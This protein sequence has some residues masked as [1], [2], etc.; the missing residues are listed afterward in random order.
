MFS[1]TPGEYKALQILG[2]CFFWV[3]W[4]GRWAEILFWQV[5]CST[6]TTGPWSTFGVRKLKKTKTYPWHYVHSDLMAEVYYSVYRRMHGLR[7]TCPLQIPGDCKEELWVSLSPWCLFIYSGLQSRH[8]DLQSSPHDS[9]KQPKLQ[10]TD[11]DLPLGFSIF[12]IPW[13]LEWG[14]FWPFT[15]VLVLIK[16]QNKCSDL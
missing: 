15:C 6:V 7:L 16:E 8:W 1:Q 2:R 9:N 4:I 13:G 5:P 11:S 3:S 12:K 10:R 14:E